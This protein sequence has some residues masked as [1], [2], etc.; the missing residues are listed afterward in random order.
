MNDTVREKGVG[1]REIEF[2]IG[3]HNM[4][5]RLKL[6][7]RIITSGFNRPATSR[8]AGAPGMALPYVGPHLAGDPALTQRGRSWIIQDDQSMFT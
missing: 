4:T 6:V 8:G 7:K 5:G 3:K 1:R 2:P